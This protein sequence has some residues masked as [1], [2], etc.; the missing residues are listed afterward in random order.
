M[1]R[2]Y[3]VQV[4][5]APGHATGLWASVDELPGC[6]ASGATLSELWEALAEAVSLCLAGPE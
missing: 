3:T 6:F 2:T 5:D 1:D 4:H